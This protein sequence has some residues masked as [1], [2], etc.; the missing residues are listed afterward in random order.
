MKYSTLILLVLS[1]SS[2]ATVKDTI[3]KVKHP[4]SGDCIIYPKGKWRPDKSQDEWYVKVTI[5]CS[6]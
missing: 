6:M 4:E 1:L 2:C 3:R 5:R